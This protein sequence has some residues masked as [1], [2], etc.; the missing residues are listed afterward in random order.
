MHLFR[1][2]SPPLKGLSRAQAHKVR[3]LRTGRPVQQNAVKN[4]YYRR[5]VPEL[6]IITCQGIGDIFW[7]YQKFFPYAGK[8]NFDICVTVMNDVIQRR[9]YNFLSTWPRVGR[10]NLK[11]VPGA[12]YE[13]IA[14]TKLF[15]RDTMEQEG[16][17]SVEY[18]CNGWLEGGVRLE[19]IDPQYP[20]S[21][22]IPLKMEDP[23]LPW[24]K[25]LA[26]YVCGSKPQFAWSLGEWAELVKLFYEKYRVKLPIAIIGASYDAHHSREMEGRFKN[27]GIETK[28]Y[29]DLP[30]QQVHHLLAKAKFFFGYQS[31]LN[32]LADNLGCPQ[33]MLYFPY[34]RN[35]LYSWCQPNHL[36]NHKY[37]ADTFDNSPKKVVDALHIELKT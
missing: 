30:P 10:V 9:A 5:F 21:W 27:L 14:H 25:Y 37:N 4:H 20:P 8:M 31:G 32:V 3:E 22:G 7:V 36:A 26:F 29:I 15:M 24:E 23:K 12:T 33:L 1:E 13:S 17:T 35:M 19:Q 28:A 18:A 2:I 6:D 11:L 16:V 34:L